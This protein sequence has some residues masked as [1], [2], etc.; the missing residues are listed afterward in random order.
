M[1]TQSY[2]VIVPANT[3]PGDNI[4]I[5]VEGEEYEILVPADS[6]PGTELQVDLPVARQPHEQRRRN[7]SKE[8]RASQHQRGRSDSWKVQNHPNRSAP[9]PKQPL[10]LDV[11]LIADDPQAVGEWASVDIFELKGRDWVRCTKKALWERI[12]QPPSTI[13]ISPVPEAGRFL[14]KVSGECL[15]SASLEVS[16]N[17]HVQVPVQSRASKL[18]AQAAQ[19]AQQERQ[20]AQAAADAAYQR[21]LNSEQQQRR[22]ME[23]QQQQQR[24]RQRQPQ[25]QQHQQ[26]RESASKRTVVDRSSAARRVSRSFSQASSER[27]DTLTVLSDKVDLIRSKIDGFQIAVRDG[28]ASAAQLSTIQDALSQCYGNLEKLQFTQIDAVVTGDLTT[29]KDAARSLRKQLSK[30]T[31]ALLN[32]VEG[33]VTEIKQRKSAARNGTR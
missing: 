23:Q 4:I 6:S 12:T 22:Q 7:S 26:R 8:K 17:T 25:H 33:L 18:A 1:S 27:I 11:S 29:G 3:W 16:P 24:Q 9:P 13:R 2:S 21:R 28:T 19:T 15:E 5:E 20:A 30:R 32:I 14:V 10:W 31:G